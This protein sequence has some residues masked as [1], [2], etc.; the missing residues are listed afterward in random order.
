M[1]GEIVSELT[2]S[3]KRC[4]FRNQRSGA[5]SGKKFLKDALPGRMTMDYRV[6]LSLGARIIMMVGTAKKQ[7]RPYIRKAEL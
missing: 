3:K 5:G 7:I 1:K 4:S 6:C 2:Y